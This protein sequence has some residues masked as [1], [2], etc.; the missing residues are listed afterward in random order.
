MNSPDRD[1][2]AAMIPKDYTD[3]EIKGFR[4]VR[5]IPGSDRLAR[6]AAVPV[7]GDSLKE[8]GILDGDILIMRITKVYEDGK[9]GVWQTPSGR[10]AKYA[11]YDLDGY[12]VLHNDNGWTQHWNDGEIRLLG[13][14]A[15]VERDL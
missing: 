13:I 3:W 9:L 4:D 7:E 6:F 14:V 12:V 1:G 15:R 11:V 2:S 10:T 8:Q 5:L